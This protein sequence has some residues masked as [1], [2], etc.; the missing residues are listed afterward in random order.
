MNRKE[1]MFFICF[2]LF[3]SNFFSNFYRDKDEEDRKIGEGRH[4]KKKLKEYLDMQVEEKRRMNEF[5]KNLD[6]EQA[7]IWKLDTEKFNTTEKDINYKV[8]NI[9]FFNLLNKY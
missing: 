2:F 6:H 5:E 9:I 8:N 1:G 3:F 4:N 7:R